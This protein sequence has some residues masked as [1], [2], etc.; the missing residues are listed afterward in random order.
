MKLTSP[1][2]QQGKSIPELYTCQGSDISP[3]LLIEEVPEEALSLVLIMDDHDVPK[4]LMPDGV[5]DHW[6]VFNIDPTVREIEEDAA[7]F[8]TLG[9]NSAG[10]SAYFGPC[11][12]DREH[13]Y[14]FRLYALDCLLDLSEGALK[15]KVL[16]KIEG[17]ILAEAELMGLYNKS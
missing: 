5:F 7:A 12:P 15:A 1:A 13:R 9:A 4:S 14:L 3:P 8:G 6:V 2:F 10:K 16:E 11:P 17:H